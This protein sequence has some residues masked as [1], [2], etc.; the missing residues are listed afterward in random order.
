M[1]DI[2]KLIPIDERPYE[3]AKAELETF[4]KDAS[5]YRVTDLE[6]VTMKPNVHISIF[7]KDDESIDIW[8]VYW[9]DSDSVKY[10]I[11]ENY[12]ELKDK[13]PDIVSMLERNGVAAYESEKNKQ[14]NFTERNKNA[15]IYKPLSH[16]REIDVRENEMYKKLEDELRD[17]K[18]NRRMQVMGKIRA[19]RELG[20]LCDNP[21]YDEAKKEQAEIEQRIDEIE[22]MLKEMI[23][24]KE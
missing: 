7:H 14:Q 9:S 19:A 20:D 12:Q 3:W 4:F 24:T 15:K 23:A 2:Y 16:I 10:S 6:K 1:T 21:A 8:R 18:L 13:H 17:L 22:K 11:L 5:R